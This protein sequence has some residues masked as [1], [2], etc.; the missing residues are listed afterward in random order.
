ML[1]NRSKENFKRNEHFVQN[2]QVQPDSVVKEVEAGLVESHR[3]QQLDKVKIK[4]EEYGE[5]LLEGE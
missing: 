2:N 5:P 3:R 1:L 4:L